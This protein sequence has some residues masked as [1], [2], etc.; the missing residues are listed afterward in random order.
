MKLDVAIV[1]GGIAGG[2]LARQLRR[3]IPTLDIGVFERGTDPDFKVGESTVEIASVYLARRLGLSTYLYEHHL[4]KNGL[5]FF[6]DDAD[7]GTAIE[8]M[9]EIGTDGLPFHPSFQLDRARLDAD[10]RRMNAEDGVLV[11]TGTRVTKIQPGDATRPHRLE[12]VTQA[13]TQTVQARWLVDASG[14]ARVLSKALGLPRVDVGHDLCAAWGRFRDV[15]D[16]DCVG[17][18]AWRDR[19][20]G[21]SRFLSTNHFCYPGY[22]I[23][24]IPIGEG[25]V[26]V[27]TVCERAHWREDLRRSEGLLAF[28][29]QHRGPAT[30]LERAT[31]IDTM[32]RANVS[33]GTT[34]FF[35]R[36]RWACVGEAAAFTD[37]FY[38]PGSDFIAL[39]NDMVTDLVARDHGGAGVGDLDER[40]ELYDAFMRLRLDANLALY[41]GLYPVLGS[42]ELLSLKWMFDIHC[43]Y[44]LWLHAYLL[45]Q[46]L[47]LAWLREQVRLRE[48]T[49]GMLDN[50]GRLFRTLEHELR[51][52]GDYHRGNHGRFVPALTGVDLVEEVGRARAR[53]QVLRATGACCNRVRAQAKALAH[54]GPGAPAVEPMPLFAYMSERALLD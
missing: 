35:S 6:F 46:H 41:R 12:L 26:S 1:G 2:T 53:K 39:E 31:S 10:L 20:R 38:S 18:R 54:G 30:L 19:V 29:R 51:T 13:G 23:W 3:R 47:D 44:N 5:R 27:G 34:R 21:T 4:P 42:F 17:T 52:R 45:E 33:Y 16:I 49:L 48:P 28:L 43:Y 7:R 37:P 14:R 15:V 11:G 25:L 8:D 32:S 50:F 24:F 40:I 36:D 22:W 9:S